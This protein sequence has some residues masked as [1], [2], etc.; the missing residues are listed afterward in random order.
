MKRTHDGILQFQL[1]RAIESKSLPYVLVA[2]TLL[3][4]ICFVQSCLM[5]W[6]HDAGAMP[7][8]ATMWIGNARRSNAE[9][10]SFLAWYLLFPLTSSIVSDSLFVDRARRST[11]LIAPRTSRR[12]YAL[13][14]A[15]TS[16]A[17][18]F[19]ITLMVFLASQCIAFVAYPDSSAPDA[20]FVSLDHAATNGAGYSAL[21]GQPFS[22]ILFSNRYLY[23]TIYCFY[24]ALLAGLMAII[25]YETSIF[26]SSSRVAVIGVP[27]MAFMAVSAILPSSLSPATSM[28]PGVGSFTSLGSLLFAPTAMVLVIAV[29]LLVSL[30]TRRDY[31][32]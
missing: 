32:L 26:V 21:E 17:G 12:G 14:G 30:V 28:L 18:A 20:Y 24:D 7:S 22:S 11:Y 25:S 2:L 31:L 1:K 3:V 6:G 29:L 9:L 13:A 15:M 5:F 4:T 27:T 23:N 10:F 16:F 19:A 8:A